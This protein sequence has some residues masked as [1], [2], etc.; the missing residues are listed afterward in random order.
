MQQNFIGISEN[1]LHHIMGVARKAYKIAKDMG[2]L[3]VGIV[4]KPFAFEGRR[5][6]E[7][8]ENGIAKLAEAVDS[9]III[10]NE[11]LKQV[12]DTRI[13][14]ANAFEIADDVLRRGVSSIV[15]LVNGTGM[16]NLDFADISAV[17]KDA[18]FA[19][20]GVGSAKGNNKAEI[21]AKAAI[22]SPLLSEQSLA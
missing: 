2:I 11:R 19:H 20:M 17:M 3:T 22:S 1:R 7:Q 16:I 9:L 13:T 21:A 10:P 6:M 14:L 18:G 5:R 15:E 8:A 4:S 12:S